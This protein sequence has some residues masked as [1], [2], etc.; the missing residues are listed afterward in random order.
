M[1]WERLEVS[2][3]N[4]EKINY[5]EFEK[6]FI[7]ILKKHGPMKKLVRANQAPY[8]T[9]ALHKEI[10]RRSEWE[11]KY[12]KLKTNNTLKEKL[13]QQT[14]KERRKNLFE[15]LTLSFVVDNKKNWKVVKALFNDKESVVSSCFVRKG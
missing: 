10:M 11:T 5:Q 12:F 15:N 14:I 2:L 8:M 7:E 13:L 4:F 1:F 6:A 9:K 3:S